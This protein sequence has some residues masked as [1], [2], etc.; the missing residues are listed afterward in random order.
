MKHSDSLDKIAPALLAAQMETPD[1]KKTATNPFFSS[2]YAPLDEILAGIKPV[3]NKHGLTIMQDI[4]PAGCISTFILHESGQ[5]VQQ[6]GMCLPLDKQT[7]QGAGSAV[8]Y[9]RRYT[10]KAMIGLA[11]DDDDGNGGEKKSQKNNDKYFLDND[12]APTRETYQGWKKTMST[13]EIRET[14]GYWVK[15]TDGGFDWYS[16]RGAE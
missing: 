12:N 7:P 4:S 8:T 3:Y 2:S 10:L 5:W 11:D 16:I 14:F 13:D 9:G 6:E 1:V 15:R